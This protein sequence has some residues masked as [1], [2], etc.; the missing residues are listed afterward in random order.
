MIKIRCVVERITYQNQENG[1]SVMKVKVKGYSDLVTLVGNLL[2]VPVERYCCA[3]AT[4]RWTSDTD[5]SLPA[6]PGKR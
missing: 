6:K 2:D 3:M 1:Y 4:G 5:S